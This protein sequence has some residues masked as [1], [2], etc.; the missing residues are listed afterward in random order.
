MAHSFLCEVCS[1]V[2][3]GLEPGA[4]DE[5]LEVLGRA[6]RVSRGR[7]AVQLASLEELTKVDQ[8][9]SV[10]NYRVVVKE[11]PEFC[12]VEP[13]VLQ[14]LESLPLDISWDVGLSVWRHYQR[15]VVRSLAAEEGTGTATRTAVADSDDGFSSTGPHCGGTDP[16]HEVGRVDSESDL[17]GS[18]SCTSGSEVVPE[19][20]NKVEQESEVKH[21]FESHASSSADMGF[22]ES[23]TSMQ[24]T[25]SGDES[26]KETLTTPSSV[27]DRDDN[28]SRDQS[29]DSSSSSHDQSRD[30]PSRQ[31]LSF[32]VTCTRGGRKH[33]FSS[34]EAASRFGAGLARCFGW[35]VSMKNYDV[36][37]L[38]DIHN[39]SAAVGIALTRESKYRRNIAHFGPTTLRS[40]I[41]YGLLRLA[42]VQPG[43][44]VVD[45]MC[46]GGSISIEGA[47]AWGTTLHLAGDVHE[48]APPRTLANLRALHEER[49]RTG[50]RELKVDVFQWDVCRLPLRTASVDVIVTDMPF[51]KK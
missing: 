12:K 10:D 19:G 8:L 28:T 30:P 39:D 13:T 21:K 24:Q 51:G 48:L 16:G 18:H 23:D 9:R 11:L 38:L 41:A 33:Q 6:A 22:S 1:T 3:T 31:P 26:N 35:K 47:L 45:P 4:A 40:T 42:A 17:G 46:G 43:E 15:A 50:K 32:R 36:E 20:E 7:I 44:V 25:P 49:Q 27:S 34:M 2:P 5:C 37:V 29:P 14:R